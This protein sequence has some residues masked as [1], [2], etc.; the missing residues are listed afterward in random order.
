[1]ANS[2]DLKPAAAAADGGG[3]GG[4]GHSSSSKGGGGGGKGAPMPKD[5]AV[6]TSVL[7]DMGVTDFEPRVVNQ[8]LEFSYRYVTEALEDARALSAHARKKAVDLEDVRLAVR[9]RAEQG[10]TSPPSREVLLDVAREKNS[11]PLP[12]PK[13]TCGLRLPPDRHCLTAC[14]YKIRSAKAPPNPPLGLG[15]GGRPPGYGVGRFP[16]QPQP[17]VVTPA[18]SINPMPGMGPKPVAVNAAAA[19]GEI[20][21][22][23]VGLIDMIR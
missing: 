16:Q 14:N 9:M 10:A 8:L 22:I 23:Q 20:P 12:V 19:A 3:G 15:R 1:M 17:K 2:S 13:A 4:G 6:M 7:R 5:A 21:S 11:A 18:F